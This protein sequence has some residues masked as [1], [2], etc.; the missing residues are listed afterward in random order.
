MGTIIQ[1]EGAV[2][3]RQAQVGLG[4]CQWVN[5]YMM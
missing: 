3:G 4:R 1:C 5:A 2:Y